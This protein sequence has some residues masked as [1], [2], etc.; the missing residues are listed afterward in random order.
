[1]KQNNENDYMQYPYPPVIAPEYIPDSSCCL[2]GKEAQTL[3]NFTHC[4]S[5]VWLEK[6]GG[7]WTFPTSFSEDTLSG[8]GWNDQEWIKVN[9]PL[10]DITG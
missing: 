10:K 7:F 4:T 5:Y 9:I 2:K 6:G 3:T 1:M 8:Y